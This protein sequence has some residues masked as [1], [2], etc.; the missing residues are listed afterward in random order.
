MQMV[1]GGRFEEL[2]LF[3]QFLIALVADSEKKFCRLVN[4]FVEKT[5]EES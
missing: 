4:E 2:L 5:K 3:Q 1:A